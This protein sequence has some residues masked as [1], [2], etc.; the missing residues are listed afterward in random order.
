MN[1]RKRSSKPNF[2]SLARSFSSSSERTA[3]ANTTIECSDLI[4]SLIQEGRIQEDELC[5]SARV[6]G[7]LAAK[8][9]GQWIPYCHSTTVDTLRIEFTWDEHTLMIQAFLKSK[10]S[11]SLDTLAMTAVSTAALTIFDV[12]KE[13]DK[14]MVIGPTYLSRKSDE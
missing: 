4:Y 7:T 5:Y 13:Y 2:F 10:T 14:G 8:N 1:R 6:A 3:I 11:T 9:P 12:C